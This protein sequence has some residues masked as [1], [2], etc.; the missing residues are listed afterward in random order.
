MQLNKDSGPQGKYKWSEMGGGRGRNCTQ[1]KVVTSPTII[2]ASFFIQKHFQ[3]K[4]LE[5]FAYLISVRIPPQEP[6]EPATIFW[7][8]VGPRH[9]QCP[10]GFKSRQICGFVDNFVDSFQHRSGVFIFFGKLLISYLSP[11]CTGP[12]RCKDVF[13]KPLVFTGLRG[14]PSVTLAD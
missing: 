14:R 11:C 4:E 7:H 2:N 5:Y 12:E 6:A 1:K 10:V 8:K 13:F 9:N 3:N